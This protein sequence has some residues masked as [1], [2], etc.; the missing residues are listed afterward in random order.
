MA[1]GRQREW[2]GWGQLM[3]VVPGE[4]RAGPGPASTVLE[5]LAGRT[6]EGGNRMGMPK[7]RW[8]VRA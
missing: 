1:E 2:G 3:T 7:G 4:G 5:N 6:P 8:G